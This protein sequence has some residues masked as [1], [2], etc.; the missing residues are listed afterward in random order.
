MSPTLYLLLAFA[1]GYS[2]G[3]IITAALFYWLFNRSER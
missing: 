1:A 3:M 2:A